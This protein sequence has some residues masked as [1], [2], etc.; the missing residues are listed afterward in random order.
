MEGRTILAMK[1][2]IGH[3]LGANGACEL[4]VALHG[5]WRSLWKLSLG[6]G[7]H[8]AGVALAKI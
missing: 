4:A 6:F 3:S 8:F 2:S 1:D 7:G 5:E